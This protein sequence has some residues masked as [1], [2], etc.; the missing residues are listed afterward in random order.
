MIDGR[1]AREEEKLRI[2]AGHRGER[3]SEKLAWG[4]RRSR[5]EG[6]ERDRSERGRISGYNRRALQLASP[7]HGKGDCTIFVFVLMRIGSRGGARCRPLTVGLNRVG[8]AP[9]PRVEP[10]GERDDTILQSSGIGKD[11]QHKKLHGG[12]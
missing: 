8:P 2:R 6:S 9:K 10:S 5:E 12:L 11:D 1:D 7:H 3:Q 4:T